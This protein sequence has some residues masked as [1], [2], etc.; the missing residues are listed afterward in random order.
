MKDLNEMELRPYA[1]FISKRLS[2]SKIISLMQYFKN[3]SGMS[4]LLAL[5]KR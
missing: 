1:G 5:D 2:K 4:N 3:L